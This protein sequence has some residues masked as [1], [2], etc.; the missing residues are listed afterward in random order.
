MKDNTENVPGLFRCGTPFIWL[1]VIVI[2]GLAHV[3]PEAARE[4]L[5]YDR[6]MVVGGQYWRLVTGHFLHTNLNHLLMNSAALVILWYLFGSYLSG[7]KTVG[8]LLLLCALCGVGLFVFNS[9]LYRYVGLSG[10]LHGL[11]V[12]GSVEDI[13][14]GA[15]MGKLL[16][17][18]IAVKTTWE[19]LGGDT[20]ATAA[21]IGADVAIDAHLWGAVAGLLIGLT[22]VLVTSAT[23]PATQRPV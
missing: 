18:G 11:M 9:D 4:W 5:V 19:Q 2:A 20:S 7:R 22:T 6:G 17:L 12:W 14:R 8:L 16:L 23:R 21:F 1:A 15:H 10:V 13:R 3:L